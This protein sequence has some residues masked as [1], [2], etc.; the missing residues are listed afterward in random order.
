M[1]KLLVLLL[2]LLPSLCFAYP[3][4]ESEQITVAPPSATGNMDIYVDGDFRFSTF[5]LEKN[6]YLSYGT[7]YD[8]TIDPTV[9]SVGT[10]LS[11]GAKRLYGNWLAGTLTGYSGTDQ[12]DKYLQYAIWKNQGFNVSVAG[13]PFYSLALGDSGYDVAVMNLWD[14]KGGDHQS[15]LIGQAN[16]VPEPASLV[17]MGVGLVAIG[18]GRKFRS[19]ERKK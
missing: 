2:V 15:L 4:L 5:C 9:E 17:L 6:V 7:V 10:P 3:V 8:I 18:F 13:N 1:K 12:D 11:L 19:K 16:P 14:Y